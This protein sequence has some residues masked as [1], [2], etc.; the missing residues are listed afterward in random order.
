M[1][2]VFVSHAATD[3]RPASW[4]VV[5]RICAC[6]R[7]AGCR[8]FEYRSET[9]SLGQQWR[10]GLLVASELCDLAIV[11]L[12]ERARSSEWV[13]FE[14]SVLFQRAAAHAGLHL[15]VL[16]DPGEPVDRVKAWLDSVPKRRDSPD[17]AGLLRRAFDQHASQLSKAE[18]VAYVSRRVSSATL[19]P[20]LRRL[21]RDCPPHAV[22]SL[23][24]R[25]GWA[26]GWPGAHAGEFG[27]S[28]PVTDS[29]IEV[30]RKAAGQAGNRES[31]T[32]TVLAGRFLSDPEAGIRALQELGH[33]VPAWDSQQVQHVVDALTS[34][35]L[36]VHECAPL[37]AQYCETIEC[38][39]PS[40][41]VF[42][43][44][45]RE[46]A[47]AVLEALRQILPIRPCVVS[48]VLDSDEAAD[49]I[50][51]QARA[52]ITEHLGGAP[53]DSL[54][55]ISDILSEMR[56]EGIPVVL[57]LDQWPG[58]ERALIGRLLQTLPG[59]CVLLVGGSSESLQMGVTPLKLSREPRERLMLRA[60]ARTM[61]RREF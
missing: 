45:S 51:H 56:R 29:V 6:L 23:L 43:V 38:A 28:G 2:L 17:L 19:A 4:D 50:L 32:A 58:L 18:V 61:L 35:L 52:R 7:T 42:C 22:R 39:V 14:Q 54:A 57:L 53:T 37:A 20:R 59:V 30:L 31:D 41:E 46:E 25:S 9:G 15:L 26:D 49:S 33:H 40:R 8:P 48:P 13:R 24:E 11:L 36:D 27:V 3:K 55:E 16:T 34:Q 44:E 47:S 1:S 12:D 21:L 10:F 5:R 60:R